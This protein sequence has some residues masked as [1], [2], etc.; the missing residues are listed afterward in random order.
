MARREPKKRPTQAQIRRSQKRLI[1]YI[2]KTSEPIDV[3]AARLRVSRKQLEN[4]LFQP[5]KS[6]FTNFRRSEGYRRLYEQTGTVDTKTGKHRLVGPI[7]GVKRIPRIKTELYHDQ[8]HGE[9]RERVF[10]KG[11]NQ[12]ARRRASILTHSSMLEYKT[13]EAQATLEW[14]IWASEHSVPTSIMDI[15]TLYKEG[16]LSGSQVKTILSHWR[17]VYDDSMTDDH[18]DDTLNKFDLD[19]NE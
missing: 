10:I 15:K 1:G 6:T 9:I 8:K 3:A 18:Y 17:A 19:N 2:A 14:Q 11:V 4:F 7:A 13:T 16:Q 12:E 5:V